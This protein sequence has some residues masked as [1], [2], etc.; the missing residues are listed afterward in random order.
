MTIPP[1]FPPGVR[2]HK[3][4]AIPFPG[5]FLDY[6]MARLHK[7]NHVFTHKI[8]FSPNAW[9]ETGV[10]PFCRRLLNQ[11][12]PASTIRGFVFIT[13]PIPKGF[14]P[15]RISVSV[16]HS[17][18]IPPFL[19]APRNE[20]TGDGLGTRNAPLPR[21]SSRSILHSGYV[22]VAL[23]R[24]EIRLPKRSFGTGHTAQCMK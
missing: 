10:K 7:A 13:V 2:S 22:S 19:R 21:F 23:W 14:R 4:R 15:N 9:R 3:P 8:F 24:S 16:F 11:R 1:S 18:Q 17:P 6:L 12:S 5:L 20:L